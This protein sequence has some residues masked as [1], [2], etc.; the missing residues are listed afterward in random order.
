MKE[1]D[2]YILHEVEQ[3]SEDWL[4]IRKGKIT[5]S[6]IGEIVGHANYSNKS[7]EELADEIIGIKKTIFDDESKKRMEKGNHF[8]PKV[9]EFMKK[10]LKKDIKEIGFVEW[11]KDP[12][13]GASLDGVIDEKTG[14]EIKCPNKIYYPIR[15]YIKNK[16]NKDDISH[17][18]KSQYD[19]IIMNGVM[20]NMEYI[21][22]IVFG[23]EEKEIF[24]QKIK[25]DYE[26]WEKELYPKA[27]YFYDNY[28]TPKIKK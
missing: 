10:E 2:T 19:Q 1:F 17:I 21:W 20:M 12:R 13:F 23:I 18:W 16:K 28:M 24:Y 27:C 4:N 14:I 7:F 11:K 8:E 5:G 26:Y 9:R 6:K 22:F 3:G 15:N 25:I